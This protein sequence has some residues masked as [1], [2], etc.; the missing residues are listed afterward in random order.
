[1]ARFRFVVQTPGRM[2]SRWL[3][4]KRPEKLT[5]E[6]RGRLA[7]L[8]RL[9]SPV[10]GFPVTYAAGGRQYVVAGTGTGTGLAEPLVVRSVAR[11]VE[12]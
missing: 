11:L 7:E 4:L 3:L 6:Q 9:G 10:S 12:R 8:V 1:M 2:R 5:D